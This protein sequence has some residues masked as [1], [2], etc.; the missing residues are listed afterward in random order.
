M[1]ERPAIHDRIEVWEG[2][3]VIGSAHAGV[4]EQA[5]RPIDFAP[6]RSYLRGPQ[7]Q[8]AELVDALDSGSSARKGVEVRVFSWAPYMYRDRPLPVTRAA[9]SEPSLMSPAYDGRAA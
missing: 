8:V 4:G 1:R 6:A 5:L 2:L 3:A 7:A 9:A